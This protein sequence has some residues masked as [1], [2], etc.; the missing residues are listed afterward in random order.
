MLLLVGYTP[1]IS[2]RNCFFQRG[3]TALH[4]LSHPSATNILRDGDPFLSPRELMASRQL[5]QPCSFP[6]SRAGKIR[7]FSNTQVKI[8]QALK[9]PK[10]QLGSTLGRCCGQ[11]VWHY[12]FKKQGSQSWRQ[13]DSW[14][15]VQARS[16]APGRKPAAHTT[17][18]S[19]LGDKVRLQ[20]MQSR[21]PLLCLEVSPC[22]CPICSMKD[23]TSHSNPRSCLKCS[24]MKRVGTY[25]CRIL[26]N[27][28]LSFQI[29][30]ECS[31]HTN[32]GVSLG[33]A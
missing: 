20:E 28:G 30:A 17:R 24:L 5:D 1:D 23:L 2:T 10:L 21:H 15:R 25:K 29:L 7:P 19:S 11:A 27:V 32:H 3:W 16:L 22:T 9:F 18:R 31:P 6:S 26:R 33:A 13:M 14:T 4:S 8:P 12:Q